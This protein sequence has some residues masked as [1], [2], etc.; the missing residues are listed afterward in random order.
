MAVTECRECEP[1]SELS[2]TVVDVVHCTTARGAITLCMALPSPR[3]TLH[4]LHGCVQQP[5][6]MS[7]LENG[8]RQALI[9]KK[10]Y[11]PQLQDLSN[12]PP[13]YTQ[14][15][16]SDTLFVLTFLCVSFCASSLYSPHT[17]DLYSDYL[18]HSFVWLMAHQRP[19][20]LQ[21]LSNSCLSVAVTSHLVPS[22][23]P[24]QIP[25]REDRLIS[26]N[27]FG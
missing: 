9:S 16:D 23:F 1:W 5:W 8:T 14:Q 15:Q 12:F 6:G 21:L 10:V 27:L 11:R 17:F 25:Q 18:D 2:C 24:I 13:E 19:S 7:P 4:T 22:T 20:C 3:H 26:L